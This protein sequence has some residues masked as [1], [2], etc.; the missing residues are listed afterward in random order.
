MADKALSA[1]E[2]QVLALAWMCF[3][4]EPKARRSP[5]AEQA[6]TDSAKQVNMA[7]FAARA[8]GV[9]PLPSPLPLPSLWT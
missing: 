8:N 7:K 1:R 6:L 2:L 4:T 3:E 9:P 5:L